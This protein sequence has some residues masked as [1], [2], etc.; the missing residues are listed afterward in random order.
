MLE[1]TVAARLLVELPQ[2]SWVV[3][4]TFGAGMGQRR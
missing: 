4:G 2:H 1:I 3:S